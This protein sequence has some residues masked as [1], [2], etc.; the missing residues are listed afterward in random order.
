MKT[1]TVKEI[2]NILKTNEE[3]VRRWIRSGKLK[4]IWKSKKE[5]NIISSEALHE[6]V[7]EMPKYTAEIMQ[8]PLAISVMLGGLLASMKSIVSISNTKKKNFSAADI[9]KFLDKKIKEAEEKTIEKTK[10]VDKLMEEI[11]DYQK[12]IEKYKYALEKLDLEL[13]AKEI[14]DK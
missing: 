1:Y 4:A 6:F 7:K 10:Q 5:G 14:N 12:T 2:A 8:S 9:K 11:K 13:I 3:T